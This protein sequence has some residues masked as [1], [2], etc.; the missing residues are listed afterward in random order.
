VSKHFHSLASGKLYKD[1]V[2]TLTHVESPHYHSRPNIRFASVLRTFAVSEHDYGQ[3]VRTFHV[4]SLERDTDEIQRR[5][6]SKY[7]VVEEANMFL[8]TNLL[9]MLRQ[10][11]TLEIFMYGCV[12]HCCFDVK[13]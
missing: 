3:Y 13:G 2:F 5:I 8:N 11:K 9:L 1:L 4:K 6:A 10:T 12:P 7:H